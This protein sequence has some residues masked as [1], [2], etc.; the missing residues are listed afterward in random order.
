MQLIRLGSKALGFVG[1]MGR[2]G[3]ARLR[4]VR[5]TGAIKALTLRS[6]IAGV[7]FSTKRGSS[8]GTDNEEIKTSIFCRNLGARQYICKFYKD[9]SLVGGTISYTGHLA[10][11]VAAIN[12]NT[13]G[14]LNTH[15]K[16]RL[17]NEDPSTGYT[18]QAG[19]QLAKSIA[20]ERL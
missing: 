2:K 1:Q 14:D 10:G 12:A 11:L 20:F 15:I 8:W 16:A 4:R 18:F 17:I 6:G 5:S 13:T 19:N 9:G 7:Q 3:R